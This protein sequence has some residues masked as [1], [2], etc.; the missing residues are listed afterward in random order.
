[1]TMVCGVCGELMELPS[2][3][4]SVG[5]RVK[6]PFCGEKTVYSPPARIELPIDEPNHDSIKPKPR[7]G[8]RRQA[9]T[10]AGDTSVDLNAQA[11]M[12]RIDCKER[13]EEATEGNAIRARRMPGSEVVMRRVFIV[14]AVVACVGFGLLLYTLHRM[15]EAVSKTEKGVGATI[16]GKTT[17]P[18]GDEVKANGTGVAEGAKGVSGA[19]SVK[20]DIA[21]DTTESE[22]QSAIEALRKYLSR[23]ENVLS[24]VVV[25]CDAARADID[26]DRR[27]MAEALAEM[28]S[29][30]ARLDAQ[31]QTNGWKRYEKAER[32]MMILKHPVMNELA[33]VYLGEDFSAMKA[34]CRSRIKT[35]LELR[36]H[37]AARLAANKEK[38]FRAREGIED[39]VE[40]KTTSAGKMTMSA[41]KELEDRLSGLERQRDNRTERLLQLKKRS[42]KPHVVENEINTL[43]D[44]IIALEKEIARVKE[45]VAVSRANV[46]HIAATV[47]ETTARRRGDSALSVRQDDDNAVH[48]EMAHVRSVFSLA[49]NYEGRSLDALRNAMRS[50]ADI[51]SVR[52]QDAQ[53]KLDYIHHAS[54]NIDMMNKD[55]VDAVK[56]KISVRLGEEII[57][58][59]R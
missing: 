21:I 17:E 41:N 24:A 30:N 12:R 32:V 48:S 42:S 14:F 35:L 58:A 28:E 52:R 10:T 57:N 20:G 27:R 2:D 59:S 56:R 13:E 9:K 54:V 22:R 49:A 36:K 26:K 55:E 1:M 7:L 19:N 6:C 16:V 3:S 33:S 8:I 37:T 43:Q 38:Y 23:E 39:E 47:A 31:A 34:E 25:E 4:L 5:Q 50:R 53:R 45:V 46:S 51:I 40:E 11:I 29:A 44:E 15:N 18:E